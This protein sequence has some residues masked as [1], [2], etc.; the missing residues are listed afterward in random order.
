MP[1]EPDD[2]PKSARI[3]GLA[4][5]K[6]RDN[7]AGADHIF[8]LDISTGKTVTLWVRDD[9]SGEGPFNWITLEYDGRE[10]ELKYLCAAVQEIMGSYKITPGGLFGPN[11]P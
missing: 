7:L 5:E 8:A 4:D 1:T 3:A 10:D 2:K 11:K 6:L 9:F